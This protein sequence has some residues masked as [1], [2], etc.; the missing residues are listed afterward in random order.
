MHGLLALSALHMTYLYPDEDMTSNTLLYK[1]HQRIALSAMHRLLLNITR[2]NCNA[3]FPCASLA[4]M[5]SLYEFSLE[6]ES[7][8]GV[9][10]RKSIYNKIAQLFTVTRGVREVLMPA[11]EWIDDGPLK[12]ILYGH[13]ATPPPEFRAP[14]E[15]LS[16][17]QSLSAFLQSNLHNT[18]RK[19]AIHDASAQLGV[20]YAEVSWAKST[21]RI[22]PG[23]ILKYVSA[24]PSEYVSMLQE[25]DDNALLLFAYYVVLSGAIERRWFCSPKLGQAALTLVRHVLDP[26][27]YQW[28][29]W[30]EAQVKL[31]LPAF[32]INSP[33][34][35][36]IQQANP[37]AS[38]GEHPRLTSLQRHRYGETIVDPTLAT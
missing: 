27:L 33:R 13:W 11:I 36:E 22:E 37:E 29:E 4:S 21:R 35:R 8:N 32:T 19:Q 16:Q 1:K 20:L 7:T 34:M 9:Y 6:P 31:G 28:L 25:G 12:P 38:S 17:L 10:D 15:I 24:V 26:K 3:A 18:V 30:P 14:D 23:L 2:D 5:F